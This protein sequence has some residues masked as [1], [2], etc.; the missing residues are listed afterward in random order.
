MEENHI[1]Q[2]SLLNALMAGACEKGTTVEKFSKTGNQGLGTFARMEGELILLD[3]AVYQ[4]REGGSVHVADQSA[5]IPFAV[6][7]NFRPRETRTL[8]LQNKTAIGGALS[9][10]NPHAHNLFLTYRIEG[11]FEYVKCRTVGGQEY[12][13]QPLSELGDK[14]SVMEYEDVDGVIVGIRSPVTFQ[15]FSVAGEHSHFIDRDRKVGGHVLELKAKSVRMSIATA[16][17]IHMELPVSDEF[18]EA[19]LKTDDEDIKNVE[20]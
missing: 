3:E 10:H 9:E 8:P 18:D 12:D 1:Y 2:Y 19:D 16:S 5:V 17:N 7:T 13:G 4:L 15:G 20:G 6:S 11:R 14:Q